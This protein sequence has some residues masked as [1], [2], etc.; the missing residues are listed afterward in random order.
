MPRRP[1]SLPL[2]EHCGLAAKL[3]ED[4]P[5]SSVY[6]E[7]GTE[8]HAEVAAWINHGRT[9]QHPKVRPLLVWTPPPGTRAEVPV[10]LVDPET[11]ELI[12]EGTTDVLVHHVDAE[13]VEV[14]DMKSGRPEFVEPAATNLQILSYALAAALE[15]GAK[16]FQATLCFLDEKGPTWDRG[17]VIVE[18][19]WWPLL[20][21]IRHAATRPATPTTGPHCD[22]CFSARHCPAYM[23]PAHE[24]PSALAPFT[25]P[26]GLTTENAPRALEVVSA[27]KE[28][29]EAAEAQLKSLARS[30]GGIRVGSKVWGPTMRA[31]RRSVRVEDV[32]AAGREDLVT[33]GKPYEV[34]AWKSAK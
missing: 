22:R 13:F 6:A 29:V 15:L 28:A 4:N 30:A 21:R 19:D 8:I 23:L 20:D 7:A 17:P 3:A 25:A 1:S 12:T 11:G 18:A 33:A 26:G 9:P 34:F 32:I 24:G 16:S 27:L 31:G 2:A 5:T 10:R 14:I